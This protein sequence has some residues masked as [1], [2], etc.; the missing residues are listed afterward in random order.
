M[1]DCLVKKYGWKKEKCYEFLQKI[2]DSGYI[3]PTPFSAVFKESA[4]YFFSFEEIIEDK[5]NNP[6]TVKIS[7]VYLDIPKTLSHTESLPSPAI[8]SPF[9]SPAITPREDQILEPHDSIVL[10]SKS[11]ASSIPIIPLPSLELKKL[12]SIDPW[13]TAITSPRPPVSA[14]SKKTEPVLD[15]LHFRTSDRRKPSKTSNQAGV[16]DKP[17]RGKSEGILNT[18]RSKLMINEI[19]SREVTPLKLGI[20]L[21][22]RSSRE[23]TPLKIDTHDPEFKEALSKL[24]LYDGGWILLGYEDNS[25]LCIQATCET[26]NIPELVNNLRD[27]EVQ[28]VVLRLKK[29]KGDGSPHRHVFITWI[30]HDVNLVEKTQKKIHAGKVAR[31]FRPFHAEL[32]AISKQHFTRDRVLHLVDYNYNVTTFVPNLI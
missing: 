17:H 8:T 26:D 32:S 19:S 20:D 28:Y 18:K 1:V 4:L 9:S 15:R 6:L 25:S 23:M 22:S 11:L 24:C 7:N 2:I 5:E 31:S 10:M 29:E 16:T 13:K 21:S 3:Q 30:G 12:D 14:H 27:N